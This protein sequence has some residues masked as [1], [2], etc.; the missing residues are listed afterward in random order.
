[1]PARCPYKRKNYFFMRFLAG[2]GF[3]RSYMY[4]IKKTMDHRCA[5]AQTLVQRT[6]RSTASLS[7]IG[8]GGTEKISSPSR[9]TSLSPK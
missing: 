2:R 7:A 8:T 9:Q 1:M 3:F 4:H 6:M 5:G